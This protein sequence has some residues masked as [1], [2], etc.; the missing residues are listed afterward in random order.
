MLIIV[1]ILYFYSAKDELIMCFMKKKNIFFKNSQI[2]TS[3]RASKRAWGEQKM[4]ANVDGVPSRLQF[5][6]LRVCVPNELER[7]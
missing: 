7:V 3:E 2:L 5:R 4:G 1:V 6:S